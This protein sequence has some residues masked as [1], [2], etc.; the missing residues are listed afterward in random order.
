MLSS[1]AGL[2]RGPQTGSS[3]PR[4]TSTT[5]SAERSTSAGLRLRARDEAA[6]VGRRLRVRIAERALDGAHVLLRPGGELVVHGA[7][8]LERRGE[9]DVGDRGP[10]AAYERPAVQ[11]EEPV[12]LE[13]LGDRGL[14]VLLRLRLDGLV[15]LRGGDLPRV[16]REAERGIG[17]T[18]DQRVERADQIEHRAVD[19]RAL[20]G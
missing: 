11:E 8:E 2:L 12:G 20:A 14:G 10:V 1:D 16:L 6:H 4:W 5:I 19:H 13:R 9:A 18:R 7:Q 17:G 3:K 15:R